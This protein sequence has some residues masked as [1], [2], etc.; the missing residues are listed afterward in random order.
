M[1]NEFIPAP[2]PIADQISAHDRKIEE[3]NKQIEQLSS[4]KEE[5]VQKQIQTRDTALET[6][7]HEIFNYIKRDNLTITRIV[8]GS[9]LEPESIE[10][11]VT[12]PSAGR[13]QISIQ[14]YSARERKGYVDTADWVDYRNKSYRND[15]VIV[16]QVIIPRKDLE[17]KLKPFEEI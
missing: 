6:L 2:P 13:N 3:L 4:S 7:A 8:E 14:L 10:A 16:M 9:S 17:D 11:Y 1:T 5:L 12:G 15:E